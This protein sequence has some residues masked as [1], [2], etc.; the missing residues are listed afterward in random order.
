MRPSEFWALTP[1]ELEALY[2]SAGRRE[3]RTDQRVAEIL[4]T[5]YNAWL[6]PKDRHPFTAADFLPKPAAQPPATNGR[7][8]PNVEQQKAL[9][10]VVMR[11]WR[12]YFAQKKKGVVSSSEKIRK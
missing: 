2:E 3:R 8:A 7:Q 9:I 6:R 5:L 12:D 10:G 4:A 1:R 11:H